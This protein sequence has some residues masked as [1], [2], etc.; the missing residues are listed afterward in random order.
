MKPRYILSLLA[1]ATLALCCACG[2]P[3]APQPPSLK[4]PKPVRDLRAERKGDKVTLT[5]TAPRLTTDQVGIKQL[6]VTRICRILGTE[7]ASA[8]TA[9]GELPGAQTAPA[10]PASFVDTLPAELQQKNPEAIV[11]Y[12]VETENA[13][14][15]SAGLSNQVTLPAAP[16]LPPPSRI[17]P[18]VTAEGPVL[19]W[20]VPTDQTGAM[21]LLPGSATKAGLSYSYRLYRREKGKPNA[22]P[23]R[24]PVESAF[25]TPDLA[26]P[27]F[28]VRDTGTEWG[29]TYVYWATVVT[30]VK[31]GSQTAEVEG[32]DSPAVEVF[33][34]DVFPPA[35]PSGLEA[36]YTPVPQQA[37][38]I[39][40]TWAPNTENDLAGYNIYRHE[41]G[42][43]PVKINSEMVK[44]P[45]FRDRNVVTGHKYSYSVSAVDLRG[46]ESEKSG[47]ASEAV[48][49]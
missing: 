33:A 32:D 4:L 24:V 41:E 25:A 39:D 5:W 27:N 10:K 21:L 19:G 42:A 34:H 16:T 12:A 30:T 8:C 2:V 49:Q 9:V 48:P 22:T 46:N 29:K 11:S 1:C 43:A 28:N 38:F 35:V 20:T 36:V 45:A 31:S 18:R 23:V 14:G 17:I 37:G 47:E 15:R 44:T 6:G 13:D 26:Q 7:P 40:L 3:G